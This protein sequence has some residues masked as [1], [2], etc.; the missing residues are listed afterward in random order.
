MSLNILH[1]ILKFICLDSGL[2]LKQLLVT[3]FLDDTTQQMLEIVFPKAN[4]IKK[5]PN[6]YVNLLCIFQIES[7]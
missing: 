4:D 6:R 7:T 3:D 5:I 1:Y 2:N